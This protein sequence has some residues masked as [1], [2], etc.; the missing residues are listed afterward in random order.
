MLKMCGFYEDEFRGL[1]D[2]DFVEIYDEFMRG[3]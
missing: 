3:V 2:Q 1:S